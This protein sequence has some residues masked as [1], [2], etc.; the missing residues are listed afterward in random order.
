[1]AQRKPTEELYDTIHDPHEI[2]NLAASDA[3]EHR[4][5]L[6]RLRTALRTWACE[7][8][9][10]G[11]V[12]EPVVVEAERRHGHRMALLSAPESRELT[13]QINS[14]AVPDVG[15]QPLVERCL[16]ALESPHAAVR[17]WCVVR[18]ANTLWETPSLEP[19][20][21]K[22]STDRLIRALSDEAAIVRV[23][24]AD[25]LCQLEFLQRGLPVLITELA[26]PD[27]WIRL[28][29]AIALDELELR[30]SGATAALETAYGDRENPYVARVAERALQTLL[31]RPPKD[32]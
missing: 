26:H 8:K 10:L 25:R 31:N 9:D 28:Q 3:P 13:A 29:A 22:A 21:K 11:L 5:A 16:A 6:E 24:A 1:M 20:L 23:A 32:L 12:P 2:Q 4:Q 30:A 17:Y 18:L 27:P 14:I 19:S 7:T 15:G